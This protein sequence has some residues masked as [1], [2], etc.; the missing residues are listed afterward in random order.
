MQDLQKAEYSKFWIFAKLQTHFILYIRNKLYQN[1]TLIFA[2]NLFW[3]K[4]QLNI[5]LQ[6]RNAGLISKPLYI[7]YVTYHY[8]GVVKNVLKKY[9]LLFELLPLTKLLNCIFV[10]ITLFVVNKVCSSKVH[11]IVIRECVNVICQ[12]CCIDH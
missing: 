10:Q 4:F 1:W 8:A 3:L 2:K 12:L 11:L 6:L 7:K 9:Q 5:L